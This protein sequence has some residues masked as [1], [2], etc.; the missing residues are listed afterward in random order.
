MSTKIYCPSNDYFEDLIK[1]FDEV[2]KKYEIIKLDERIDLIEALNQNEVDLALVDPITYANISSEIEY[3]IVPTKCLMAAGYTG[4]ANIYFA[5][6]L[7]EIENM[8]YASKDKYLAILSK[9]ILKE[10][11]SFNI[12]EKELEKVTINH[13]KDYDAV[14]STEKYIE[15][16]NSL[17]LTEEWFDTFEYP[18]PIAFWIAPENFDYEAISKLTELLFNPQEKENLVYDSHNTPTMQYEREGLI[19]NDFSDEAIKSLEEIIQLFYQHGI[20]EDMKD[21]RILGSEED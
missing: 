13:L 2:Q 5:K 6:Y 4:I 12:K 10:K 19:I 14:L 9:I 7:R 8:V 20:I 16:K 21:I 17:D 1:N 15:H 18:L 3:A 11:Y